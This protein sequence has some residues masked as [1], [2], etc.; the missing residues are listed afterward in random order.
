[1]ALTPNFD[2]IVATVT[3]ADVEQFLRSAVP[4]DEKQRAAR[5]NTFETLRSRIY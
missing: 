4:D 5:V 1:M 3:A 2:R